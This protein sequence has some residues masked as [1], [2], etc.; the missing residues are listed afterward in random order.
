MPVAEATRTFAGIENENEFYSHHYLAEVFLGNIRDQLDRW[1]EAEAADNGPKAPPALLKSLA[2]RWFINRGA[3]V[4]TRDEAERRQKFLE[5]QTPLFGALGYQI[6]PRELELQ[7][8]LPVP[9]WQVL[10]K[11]G[12]AP[13][14]VIAPVFD[15][16]PVGEEESED[17]LSLVLTGGQY[18][19]GEVPAK[20]RKNV[21]DA[22]VSEA[23]FGADQ[24]P[25]YVI[26]AGV[27]EW[28]LLDRFKWPNN[29]VLRFNW[30]EILDRRETPT[31]Q[32]AAALL[33]RESLVP[34]TGVPLLETLEENAHKHAFGVSE[35][36]KYALREA[37]EIIGNE[38]ARQLRQQAAESKKGFFSG[39]DELDAEKLSRECLRLV[40]R[41]LFLFYVESR[42]ELGY[43]PILKSDIYAKGYSLEMLRDL[44][45]VQLNTQQARDG[46]FF[47]DTLQLLFRLVHNGAGA[48]AQHQ[49]TA[50]TVRDVFSLAP[51]DSRLFDPTTTPLLNRVRLPNWVWQKVIESMSLSRTPGGRTGRVS[52]Q[53]LS[54]NQLGAVY[55]ALL[56]YRG[57]FATEDLYE[58]M[59]AQKQTKAE[60][61]DEEDDDEGGG[62]EERGG[63][64][65]LLENAWFVPASRIADYR[66][67]E[68]VTDLDEN[69]N[70]RNRVHKKGEFIYRLAGRDRKKSASYYTLQV[71]TRCLV[72]YALKELLAGKKA[73]EIL[74]LTV[75]EPAMG[76]AA[77]LNEAVNQLSEAY[78]ERKQAELGK[79]IPHHLYAQELQKV[80]MFIADRNVFGID[81][82]PVAVELAEVS[83]W[84]NAIY[85]E[86]DDRGVPLPARGPWFG[87]QLFTG[88]SLIGA[89]PE[90]YSASLLSSRAQ[91]KWHEQAPRRLDPRK[92]NRRAD[93]IYHFLLPDPAMSDYKDKT[94]KA[95]YPNEF[96]R[97]KTWRQ[98]F[99]RPLES[100]EVKLLLELS[101]VIDDLWSEHAI[102][103]ARDRRSTED[104]LP[105]WPDKSP[106]TAAETGT[107]TKERIRQQGLL[108]RDE[109]QATPYR[110]LKLVLDYWC[111]LWFWPI[112]SEVVM[113]S[114]ED[115]WQAVSAI[116]RGNIVAL[117]LQ[118]DLDFATPRGDPEPVGAPQTILLVTQ[119]SGPH[120]HDRFG[121]LRISRLRDHFPHIKEVEQIAESRKFLHW[122]LV[123][124]DIFHQRGGF[125]L[126]LG[127]PPWIVVEWEEAGILGEKNPSFAIRKLSA[128]ELTK[129]RSR[130]FAEFEGLQAAWT[131][132][133]EEASAT[134][135]FLGAVQNYP[136]LQGLRTNLYKCFLPVG[137]RLLQ[138]KGVA[139]FLH[140]EGTYDDP[141]GGVLREAIYSRLRA[142]FQFQNEKKLFPIGNRNK[143]G[144]NIYGTSVDPVRF[145]HCS[146]LLLPPTID[147]SFASDGQSSVPGIKTDEGDWELTGHRDRIIS[148]TETELA[149]FA[150]LYDDPGTPPRHAR[151]PS[152]HARMLLSVLEKLAKYPRRLGDLG[153]ACFSSQ[154][155]NE[156]LAQDDGTITRNTGFVNSPEE[157]VLS[158]PH[159]SVASPFHQTPKRDCKT[160][161]AYDG[162]DLES[163]PDDYLPR[164]NYRPMA[165]RAEYIRR[166]PRVSWTDPGHSSPRPITD[167]YRLITRRALSQSGERTLIATLLLP[168]SAHIDSCF[169]LAFEDTQNLLSALASAA[170]VPFDFFVKSTGKGDFRGD[171][172]KQ[173]PLL[174][175]DTRA[176][177]RIMLLNAMSKHFSG[178]WERAWTVDFALGKW[179]REDHRLAPNLFS[180][181]TGT[182]SSTY[183]LRNSFARR[184]ALVELDVLVAQALGLT[185][186]ELL[187]IYRV[188]FPVMQQYERDTWYDGQ[189]RIVFT[190]SKGLVGVGL[191]RRAGRNDPE[192][193]LTSADG[194]VQR[195]RLGWEDVRDVPDGTIVSVKVGDDTL[196]G[197]PHQRECRWVSP[198][199]TADREADYRIAWAFFASQPKLPRDV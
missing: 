137:W 84:L 183:P 2:N 123:F 49:L 196:P 79:R 163:I 166:T 17:I 191:P 78:L 56:S 3:L 173:L 132:E 55:E 143:F 111:A 32:A 193:T 115:W 66:P 7:P 99:C 80:R 37:I 74:S 118:A 113:P 139:G 90:V 13:S 6:Q 108:N 131:M 81:L 40:Y 133:L 45:R 18:E 28:L 93:E 43:V 130:A 128:T 101:S 170:T 179:S 147:T 57:F 42:P 184:Q 187:L 35:S 5:Q 89:R 10:G 102:W 145:D 195:G 127:N 67:S 4:K 71:L 124:A 83:L 58:V 95:L 87:Y 62:E 12:S 150:K 165:D 41:L 121:N 23:I 46:H 47:D 149:L 182:W 30:R 22:V 174:E 190:S 169:S 199:A 167:Y 25:R 178:M 198:F 77:F 19:H 54:I 14:L 9:V 50:S 27:D 65:D 61:A 110:R 157:W 194:R 154:H 160:H 180:R 141:Q 120:L 26:L 105:I 158:G 185:L 119:P 64:T 96:A 109:D 48:V 135:T 94:A 15:G 122:E 175:L 11:P 162:I 136:L 33:H 114:R 146:N 188:Q 70:R 151:L 112:Q 63:T 44:E 116:L 68:I 39:K 53:L 73:N 177:V 140:P 197:G 164:T 144:I 60:H 75:C 176:R 103:L 181:L 152:L 161:R 148:V 126:I 92:P 72:K 168:G 134:Q 155:W 97:L 107:A 20:F 171:L 69:R 172:A 117:N 129:E 138:L 16:S 192:V 34:D 159:F 82:N 88:N 8:G 31:L 38:A 85:G 1:N 86:E 186:E 156:K 36:L 98:E 29:R 100:H 153:V 189:G 106:T 52:Y 91:P 104:P 51:L 24:A 76:S 21:W 59:P 125:D 142:H